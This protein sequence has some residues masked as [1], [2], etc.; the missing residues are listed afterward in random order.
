MEDGCDADEGAPELE[1]EHEEQ[2]R[3]NS[4]EVEEHKLAGLQIHHQGSH[5]VQHEAADLQ[6]QQQTNSVRQHQQLRSEDRGRC[7]L[8]PTGLVQSPGDPEDLFEKAVAELRDQVDT[9]QASS[10]KKG[11]Q[12]LA[13]AESKAGTIGKKKPSGSQVTAGG[14]TQAGVRQMSARTEDGV[15]GRDH[16]S[17]RERAAQ[18]Q[19]ISAAC[20]SRRSA[21]EEEEEPEAF[22]V[23][24]SNL[25]PE[26]CCHLLQ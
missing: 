3:W 7:A 9:P 1:L 5:N 11:Q 12:C 24:P 6:Q 19:G 26:V 22:Y 20:S 14:K 25:S 8:E 4:M 21:A 13:A 18:D 16:G 2:H 15:H 23:Y 10:S 17:T